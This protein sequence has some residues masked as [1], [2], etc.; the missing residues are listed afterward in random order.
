MFDN[1]VIGR[2]RAAGVAQPDA[3]MQ[4]NSKAAER[5]A[6]NR[7]LDKRS[8]ELQQQ[9]DALSFRIVEE[10][11]TAAE[12][13]AAQLE[14]EKAQ[15]E[16]L[17]RRNENTAREHDRRAA[18]AEDAAQE[19]RRKAAYEKIRSESGKRNRYAAEA[20]KALD[21]AAAAFAKVAECNTRIAM[22]VPGDE[23][24]VGML[25]TK[26]SWIFAVQHALL[27]A[28]RRHG[29]YM[30]GGRYSNGQFTDL[31]CAVRD[32][33][34]ITAE[35]FSDAAARGVRSLRETIELVNSVRDEPREPAP[36]AATHSA[37]AEELLAT[38]AAEYQQA[39]DKAQAQSPVA[40]GTDFNVFNPTE[41]I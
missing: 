14:V 11:D 39:K 5:R 36:V 24:K 8:V 9:I 31:A 33:H 29:F 1:R 22:M 28:G 18:E 15:I 16:T 20:D 41:E 26:S 35:R 32:A 30:P 10:G 34:S 19:R 4:A 40:L 17:K 6:A 38:G 37:A 23:S 27:L 13:E 2:F 21:A 12:A 3:V 25:T 7:D